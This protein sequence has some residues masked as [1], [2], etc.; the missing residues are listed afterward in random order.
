M[1]RK[2]SSNIM[3][4]VKGEHAKDSPEI[5]QFVD[6]F[7]SLMCNRSRRQI[8]ELLAVPVDAQEG[9][10]PSLRERRSTDIA[11]ELGLSPATTSE[12]LHQLCDAKLIASRRDRNAVYYRL[13]NEMLVRAFRDLVKALS[14]EHSSRSARQAN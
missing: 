14:K 9:M 3:Q 10:K 12:H 2:K 8:L 4:P 11:R 5:D 7:L 6:H 13:S 1:S